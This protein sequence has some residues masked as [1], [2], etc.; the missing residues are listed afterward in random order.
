[1]V[2]PFAPSL[3][4]SPNGRGA[5][6]NRSGRYEQENREA[7]DDGWSVEDPEPPRL[8]TT[9]TRETARTIISRNTSPDIGFDRT[10]NTYRGCEHGCIYCYARPNHAY[11]GLSPGLDFESRLFAKFNAAERLELELSA[12][13]YRA[14][15]LVMGGVTDVYQPIERTHRLT[16]A[17]LEVLSRYN[18][19]VA[20]ITKSA[21]VTRDIDLLA[22][23]AAK[24]LAKVAVSITTLDRKL[25]RTM[26]PR[27]ATPQRRLDAVKALADAGIPVAVMTAPLIPSLNDAELEAI[28]E[29]A[30]KAGA[31]EAGY[32][33]LRLPLEIKDLF[34]EWLS[35]SYPDRAQRVMKLVRDMRGGRDYDPEWRARQRGTGPYARLIATRFSKACAR[36]GLNRRKLDLDI[37]QFRAP[38]RAG[39]QLDLL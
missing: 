20:M 14:N 7:F 39:D 25:A 8:T 5:V 31:T 3:G 37:T 23:M 1:M 12:K 6:T 34:R 30:A 29:A 21:L 17:C 35:E 26:E 36:Y 15:V 2:S 13:N 11:A 28:L 32:V 33:I 10:I 9:V 22:P 24:N 16:R 38:P 4:P 18:H 19:P 27:A